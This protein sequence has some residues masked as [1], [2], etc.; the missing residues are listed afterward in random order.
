MSFLVCCMC[1][2]KRARLC[3]RAVVSSR[4]PEVNCFTSSAACG[5][6]SA[7]VKAHVRVALCMQPSVVWCSLAPTRADSRRSTC[8]LAL[9]HNFWHVFACRFRVA[10][11]RAEFP[12]LR[13]RGSGYGIHA[14]RTAC[15]VNIVSCDFF[16]WELL[17]LR[18]FGH[19]C[20]NTAFESEQVF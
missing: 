16:A 17:G 13:L 5:C 8:A 15:H 1:H 19:I 7:G 6:E 11:V 14:Q 18:I 12:V 2:C 20:L 9:Q 3:N 4:Q 10:C